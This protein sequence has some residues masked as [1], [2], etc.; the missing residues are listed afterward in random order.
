[1]IARIRVNI[2]LS[3]LRQQLF[4]QQKRHSETKQLLFSISSKIRSGLNIQETLST[5]VQEI[6][7]VLPCNRFFIVAVENEDSRIMAFSSID[8]SE[9]NLQGKLVYFPI[10]ESFQNNQTEKDQNSF[11]VVNETFNDDKEI[12]VVIFPNYYLLAVQS[13]VSL[14]ALP[15]KIDSKTWGWVVANRPPNN[16]W[17]DSEK[18]FL[19]Q[20]SNQISLAITHSILL[21]EKLKKEAQMEAMK[22]ANE[23]KSQ[24]L[25]NT[26][27]GWCCLYYLLF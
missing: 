8:Q 27:H 19:Q 22:A 9:P 20:I 6:H 7:N 16:T 3:Y 17:L 23:A 21:E 26:S 24:I 4:L 14:I 11:E 10:K 25:A 13:L 15:I 18:S 5:A 1:M 2:K 12:E